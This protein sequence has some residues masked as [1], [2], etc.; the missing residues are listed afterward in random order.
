M[1]KLKGTQTA[2]NLLIAF[3]GEAQARNRYT[4]YASVAKKEGYV[5]I[6]NIFEET[7]NQEKEHAKRLFKFMEDGS[8]LEITG[9][10]PWGKIGK[11]TE[12]LE[13]A[14]KGEDHEWQ[15]MYPEYADIAEKEGFPEIASAMRHIAVAEKEHSRRYKT[16]KENIEMNRVFHKSEEVVWRCQNCGYIQKGTD[17]PKLCP[18]CAHPQ[19]H[20]E[21]LAENW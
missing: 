1:S 9:T 2:K 3:S 16:L 17:A 11:T 20:F 19:A 8:D 4:Y 18:A 6:A 12:N 13:E 7:A 10:F 14:A 15:H 21:L 5:Q